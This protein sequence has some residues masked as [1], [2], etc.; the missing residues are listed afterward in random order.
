[1]EVVKQLGWLPILIILTVVTIICGVLLK[2]TAPKKEKVDMD[3][4]SDREKFEQFG[5]GEGPK[6]GQDPEE[7]WRDFDLI[8]Q[9]GGKDDEY[10]RDDQF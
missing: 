5:I 8:K 7:Y 1:M 9:G 10:F 2:V 4:L 6:P 3:S